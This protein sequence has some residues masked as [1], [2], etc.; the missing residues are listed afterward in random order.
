MNV[1]KSE[2]DDY[3]TYAIIVNKLCDDFKLEELSSD[4]FKWLIF[5]QGLK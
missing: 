1:T 3:L 5:V 2:E 4:N